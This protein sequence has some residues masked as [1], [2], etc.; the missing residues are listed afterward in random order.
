MKLPMLTPSWTAKLMI[1]YMPFYRIRSKGHKMNIVSS[2]QDKARKLKGRIVLPEG[3]EERTVLAAKKLISEGICT[4]VLIGEID[5]ITTLC[6][7]HAFNPDKVEIVDPINDSM[8]DFYADEYYRIRKEKGMTPEEAREVMQGP[9]YFGAMMVRQGRVD[10]SVAGALSTTGDVLRA[11]IQII[12]LAKGIDVVSSSF[13]MVLPE[14][15]GE[16]GKLFVFAD[17][18]VLPDPTAEQLASIAISS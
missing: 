14:F 11:A 17:C 12:G 4:P 9:L 15:Q 2:I 18:A 5:E 3:A 13:L 7:K 16:R 8:F 6:Q 1:L 10:G